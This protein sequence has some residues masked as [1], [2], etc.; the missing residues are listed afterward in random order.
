[1][2]AQA[3]TG[4][5]VAFTN[6]MSMDGEAGRAISGAVSRVFAT[7]RFVGGREVAAFEEAWAAYCG[8]RYAVGT[9]SGTTALELTLRALGIGPGDEVIVPGNTFVATAEAVAFVGARPRFVDVDPETLLMDP[10]AAAA[11]IGRATRA[12]IAVHLYGQLADVEAL[13]RLSA[14]AGIALI[15]DAAQAHGATWRGR[16]AGAFGLAGCFS[17]YPSKNLGAAGD[18]GA[19]VTDDPDLAASIRRL[20]DHGRAQGHPH[21]HA[22]IGTTGRID[23]LQA[24]VVHAK[25]PWLDE[26]NARRR[27]SADH[28]RKLLADTPAAPV[29]WRFDEAHVAHLFVVQVPHRDRVRMLLEREG[30]ETGVHYP[31]PCHLTPAFSAHRNGRIP[32]VERSAGRVLSLPMHP[33]LEPHDVDRVCDILL[34]SVE[35][36]GVR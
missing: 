3:S 11:A 25:L 28:Y 24:A 34:R 16:R 4:A 2:T 8:T 9:S 30:I 14:L 20:T 23:A 22:S 17:F 5:P 31:I 18:A 15:E 21:T 10:D 32:V 12:I 36:V 13:Q 29:S 1:M 6:L 33:R 27:R 35:E 26:W 7:E 19:V